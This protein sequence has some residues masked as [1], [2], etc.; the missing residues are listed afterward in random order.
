MVRRKNKFCHLPAFMR[1]TLVYMRIGVSILQL[2]INKYEDYFY[3]RT[4]IY[5]IYKGDEKFRKCG[6]IAPPLG[7]E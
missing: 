5:Y 4:H 1:D 7:R 3:M 2:D 6:P